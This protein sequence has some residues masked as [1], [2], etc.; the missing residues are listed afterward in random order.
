MTAATKA[1]LG[2]K[3]RNNLHGVAEKRKLDTVDGCHD[4]P[5]A[6]SAKAQKFDLK[7]DDDEFAAFLNS[8][9]SGGLGN[10]AMTNAGPY[11]GGMAKV[12]LKSANISVLAID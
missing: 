7:N 4:S 6:G 8:P 2:E 9:N 5:G 11:G 10:V 12:Q 3:L 1:V